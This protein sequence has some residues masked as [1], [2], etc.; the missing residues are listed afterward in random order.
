MRKKKLSAFV[1]DPNPYKNPNGSS[2]TSSDEW[3]AGWFLVRLV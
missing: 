1:R 2:V 3:T